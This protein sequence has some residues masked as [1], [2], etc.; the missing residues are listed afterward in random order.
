MNIEDSSPINNIELEFLK[1]ELKKG[2]TN[3]NH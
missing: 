1:R 2:N 3:D